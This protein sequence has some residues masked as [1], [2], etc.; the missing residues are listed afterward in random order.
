MTNRTHSQMAAESYKF[1]RS[2]NAYRKSRT[3]TLIQLGGLLSLS[4]LPSLLDIQAGED[5]QLDSEAKDKAA[6]LL[7]CLSDL[8]DTLDASP[9]QQERWKEKG[10]RTLKMR[11]YQKR[12]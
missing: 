6:I 7:G 12:L 1:A 11:E 3:R 8:I 10:M 2:E 4:G 5:L 9:P